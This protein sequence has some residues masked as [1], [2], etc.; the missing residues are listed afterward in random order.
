VCVESICTAVYAGVLDVKATACLR[1]RRPR[2]RRQTRHESKHPGLP[3]I[4]AR[5]AA[6]NERSELGHP[7]GDQII[8]ANNASSML[9]LTE[10]LTR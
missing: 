4:A 6:V 3:N 10:R 5:P 9:W 8:G 7:E 1:S 2:R